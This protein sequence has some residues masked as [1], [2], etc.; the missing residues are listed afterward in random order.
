MTAIHIREG[1]GKVA[2]AP[3]LFPLPPFHKQRR[4]ISKSPIRAS[5]YFI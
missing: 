1:E 4:V 2:A 3:Q 5:P